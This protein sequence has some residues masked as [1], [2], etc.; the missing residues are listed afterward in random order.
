MPDAMLKAASVS[1]QCEKAL[2]TFSFRRMATS[3]AASRMNGGS[4]NKSL[5]TLFCL[6]KDTGAYTEIVEETDV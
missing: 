1:S 2:N 6:P 3:E 4:Q 5:K